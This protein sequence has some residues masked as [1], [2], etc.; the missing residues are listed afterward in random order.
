MMSHKRAVLYM[1]LTAIIWSTGGLLIKWVDWNP[2]GIAGIRSGIA[3]LTFFPFIKFDKR[4]FIKQS[5]WGAIA[6][7]VTLIL[8]V[9]ANKLTTSAN[10]IFLQNTAPIWVII[11]SRFILKVNIRR[12]DTIS[13]L[14]I[15]GGM[16]LFFLDNMGGGKFIGNLLA[17]ISGVAFASMLLLMKHELNQTPFNTIFLG[18]IITFFVCSPFY[19]GRVPST[20]SIVGLLILGVFQ[21]GLSYFLYAMAIKKLTA[22]EAILIPFIEPLLNP[23]WVFLFI[24]ERP[25][26]LSICGG[27]IVIV[28]LI[29]RS[30]IQVQRNDI[31]DL[32]SS[33]RTRVENI[34]ETE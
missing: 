13:V 26:L 23:V 21:I 8:F 12:S 20:S 4:I 16:C 5:I 15:L 27:I 14:I 28:T 32:K 24:G 25:G 2:M 7:A 30:I 18:N 29:V 10:A 1:I 19:F 11:F 22:I 31:N 17:L 3:A 6:Y 33:E 9:I 34:L